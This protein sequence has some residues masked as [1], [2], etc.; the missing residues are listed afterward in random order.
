MAITVMYNAGAQIS[1]N[2]LNQNLNQVGKSL[3]KISTGQKFNDANGNAASYAISEKMLEK[4][5]TLFQDDQNIQNG[6]AMVKTAERG[7]DQIVENLR[8]MKELAIDAAND[9]NTDEDRAIIQKELNQR[10]EV[11]NDIALGTKYNGKILL[12]GRY[13]GGFTPL[14][15]GAGGLNTTIPNISNSFSAGSGASQ[16]TATKNGASTYSNTDDWIFTVNASFGNSATGSNVYNSTFEVELDFSNLAV[17]GSYPDA[18]HGQGF[19]ILCSGCEQY[20]NIRFDASKTATMSTYNN[21]ANV[22]ANGQTNS[23]AR[24]FTIGVKDVKSGSELANTIF[25][26]VSAV[27]SQITGSYASQNTADNLLLDNSHNVRIKRDPADGKV[28][29]TKTGSLEMQFLDGTVTNPLT[30]PLT[31]A[32]AASKNFNPLWVQHGTQSGQR[33]HVYIKDMQTKSLGIDKAEVTTREAATSAIGTIESAIETALDEATT[34]GAYLQRLETSFANVVTM[35]EN[36]QGAESTIRDA[37]MAKEITEYTKYN[38]LVYS[39]QAML[40][41]S[42]QNSSFVLGMLQ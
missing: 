32:E 10:R 7:I 34:M 30:L 19:T 40:T 22:S 20:I 13:T 33:M 14:T 4:I 31:D 8:T 23:K 41:Q 3:E 2:S 1:L 37:D 42:N 11:I 16:G 25:E 27:S 18:L 36:V 38:I 24:E 9:S 28:Y 17:S 29:F 21:T 39:A 6:S 15:D 35:R 5:R 12:D 26:G